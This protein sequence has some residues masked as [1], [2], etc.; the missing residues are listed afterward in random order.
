[1]TVDGTDFGIEEPVPFNR[2][3]FSHKIKAAALRYEIGVCLKTGWIVWVHGPFPAGAWPD[4]K[5]AAQSLIHLLDDTEN[6]VADGGYS[7]QLPNHTET[8]TGERHSYAQA[9]YSLAR[10]RHETVN[11]R[12][13]S[14][15]ILQQRFRHDLLLHSTIFRAIANIIQ[16]SLVNGHGLF[17]I[18][19]NEADFL[20]DAL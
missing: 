20:N 12:F 5:I 2:R 8:P 15:Q 6:F 9:T 11:R 17:S 19:Y 18:E 1:M 4:S 10:A 3:W 14:F 16:I 7:R 13:K